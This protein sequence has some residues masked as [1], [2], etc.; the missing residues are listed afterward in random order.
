MQCFMLS[1][2][3]YKGVVMKTVIKEY[4]GTAIAV[5]TTCLFFVV[6]GGLLF[7]RDGMLAN[8]IEKVLKGG[9]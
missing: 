2:D 1:L 4:A 7:H 8:I 5:L 9:V 3:I 6:M